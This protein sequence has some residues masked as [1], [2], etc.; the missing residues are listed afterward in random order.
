MPPPP[1]PNVP[2]CTTRT[3]AP[4]PHTGFLSA[5]LFVRKIYTSIK[6]E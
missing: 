5:W 4:P 1:F 6:I 2:V 3:T